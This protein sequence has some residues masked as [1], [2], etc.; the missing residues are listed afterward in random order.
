[1]DPN[2]FKNQAIFQVT[3]KT[4]MENYEVVFYNLYGKEVQRIKNVN[5][6]RFEIQRDKLKAGMYICNVLDQHMNIVG[7]SRIIIN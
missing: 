6:N 7:I 5:G 4:E 3:S 2:P 1:M